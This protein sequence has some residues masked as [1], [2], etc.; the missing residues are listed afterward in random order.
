MDVINSF[1]SIVLGAINS[2]VGVILSVFPDSPFS[3]LAV[4]SVM[5]DGLGW[6]NWFFPVAAAITHFAVFLGAIVVYMG[7]R[8]VFSVLQ[9]VVP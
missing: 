7:V 4:S 5:G 8:W 3:S 2:I 6:L 9:S 1:L